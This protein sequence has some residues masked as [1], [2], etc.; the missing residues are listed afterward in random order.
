VSVFYILATPAVVCVFLTSTTLLISRRWRWSLATLALQY[1]A[2][3]VLIAINAPFVMAL[4]KLVAGWIA[5]TVLA[6]AVAGMFPA[7]AGDSH[8]P[9]SEDLIRPADTAPSSR[10]FRLLAVGIVGLAVSSLSPPLSG[11]VP[12]IRLEQGW[13]ALILIGIGILHLGF[14]TRTLN[15]ILGLLTVLSGFEIL[16]AVVEVS[17]LVTGLLAGV[18]LGLALVGTYLLLAPTLLEVE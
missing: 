9:E 11:W 13:G 8:A 1:L 2:V 7:G 15:V 18:T 10:L 4:A 3:F 12:G 16:Y 5:A 6:I 14:T 17:A